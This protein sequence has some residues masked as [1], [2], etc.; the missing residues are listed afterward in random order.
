MT[1]I[2]ATTIDAARA[3]DLVQ[4]A[5]RYGVQLRKESA[6]SWCGPCPACG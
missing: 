3:T 1:Q 4:L 5:Q 6:A 2:P